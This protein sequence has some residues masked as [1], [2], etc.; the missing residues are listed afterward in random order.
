MTQVL[1][2]LRTIFD[3]QFAGR[4]TFD[5]S[6]SGLGDCK[7][8][9]DIAQTYDLGTN[10]ASIELVPS[11]KVGS[12]AVTATS[13]ESDDVVFS[14]TIVVPDFGTP[15]L[16]DLVGL[17]SPD[18]QPGFTLVTSVNG[19]SGDVVLST[20]GSPVWGGIIGTLNDQV[21][22]ASRLSSAVAETDALEAELSAVP[23]LT[24][25]FNNSLV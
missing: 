14:A 7:I 4:I 15:C 13:D 10:S 24:L 8:Y 20:S 2:D 21:D 6:Q 12:Y 19:Q 25:L 17:T 18:I 11:S 23:N 5:P 16:S 9:L 3:E 22:L 1:V